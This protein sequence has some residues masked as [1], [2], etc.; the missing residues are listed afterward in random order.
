MSNLSMNMSSS[1]EDVFTMSSSEVANR[2]GVM[3]HQE[4]TTYACSDYIGI[5][6]QI[7]QR[8]DRECR[9][10]MTE[11]T[12][13]LVDFCKFSRNTVAISMSYLDRFLSTSSPSA[14]RAL[15]SKKEYQLAAMVTLYLSVKLFEPMAMDP[16]LLA[17]ISQG[18]YTEI[19]IE[20]MEQE[21]LTA[22]QWRLNGPTSLDFMTHI[23][24]LLPKSADSTDISASMALSDFSRFQ[25]ELSVSDYDLSLQRKSTIALAS[26]LNSLEGIDEKLISAQ[27]RFKFIQ[28]ISTLST[29]NPFS[30]E[31][32]AARI[33]LLKLFSQNS[34]YQLPQVAG[35]TPIF[36]ESKPSCNIVSSMQKNEAAYSPVC[37]GKFPRRGSF[38]RCA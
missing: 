36:C 26:I 32:N 31:I 9:V 13:Q 19:E 25:V 16:T 1:S 11:W 8:V 35:L 18:C 10:K 29:I 37:V 22:L 2:I 7:S 15:V 5:G 24:S 21:I 6:H 20:S 33:R 17:D 12:Y 14:Q 27:Q 34:G 3:Q 23:L 38:A 30:I 4:S 28:R